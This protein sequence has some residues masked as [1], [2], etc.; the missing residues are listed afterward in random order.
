MD[1]VKFVNFIL[2]QEMYYH[3]DLLY[4]QLIPQKIVLE[5][6]LY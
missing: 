1:Y 6:F 5:K 3:L 4:L 2:S